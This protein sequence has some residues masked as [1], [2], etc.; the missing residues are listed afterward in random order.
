MPSNPSA[1]EPSLSETFLSIAAP[2]L[3]LVPFGKAMPALR[4]SMSHPKEATKAAEQIAA[5]CDASLQAAVFLYVDDIA[6][7]HEAAQA[8]ETP[9]GAYWHGIVHRREGDFSNAKYWF[10]RAGSLPSRL[11]LSPIALTDE[12]AHLQSSE[13]PV[14]LVDAQRQE[15]MALFEHCAQKLLR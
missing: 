2:L 3:D 10:R 13:N 14:N 6:R 5:T 11:N 9:E 15:W 8:D 4:D 12:V 7:A 1:V